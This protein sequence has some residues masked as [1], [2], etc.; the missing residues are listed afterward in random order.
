M[1]FKVPLT[2]ELSTGATAGQVATA[3]GSGG[4]FWSAPTANDPTTTPGDMLYRK[5]TD[6]ALVI[7]FIGDS[8]T[9]T[10]AGGQTAPDVVAAA[11]TGS[12]ITVTVDNEGFTATNTNHW[13]PGVGYLEDA[14]TS[15]ASSGVTLV[16]IML[17]T[18]DSAVNIAN[19]AA[20][21]GAQLG[22]IA[23]DL[24]ADGYTVVLSYPPYYVPYESGGS[25][26]SFTNASLAR[27]NTYWAVIDSLCN[28]VTIIQGDKLAYTTFEADHSLLDS[29]GIHPSATGVTSLGTLWANALRS[30]VIN[31]TT[32]LARLP[33]GT[34]GQALTVAAGVP[35][36]G[37]GSAGGAREIL[38]DSAGDILMDENN[39]ILY[40][41]V[42]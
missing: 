18:N 7:G 15:F 10:S 6:S 17:G 29:G 31:L 25:S 41:E 16:H 42:E 36:W 33:I 40:V 3:D 4:V 23:A 32:E 28:G 34:T 30:T 22:T 13:L 39:N 26:V 38:Q 35:T 21:F 24:V 27:L 2:V 1:T 12:G 19:D 14:K 5:I 11:L 20:T 37:A 9:A 8:I